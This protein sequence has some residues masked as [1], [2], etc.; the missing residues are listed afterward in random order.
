MPRLVVSI[1]IDQLRTDYLE[2]FMPYYSTQGFKKLLNEGAV[3]DNAVYT[4]QPVDRASAVASI[5][6]GTVPR[7]NGITGTHWLDKSTLFPVDCVDDN[8]CEGLFTKEKASP[9]NLTATTIGD[10]LK[11][12]TDGVALVYSIAKDKEAAILSGGHAADGVFWVDHANK[13]WCSSKFYLKKAPAWMDS[14]NILNVTDPSKG[15]VNPEITKLALHCVSS[16]SMGVDATPDMLNVTYDAK[17]PVGKDKGNLLLQDTYIQLDR[18]IETLISKIETKVGRGNVLFVLTGTGYCND[19]EPD[20]EKFRIQTGTFYINRTANLLNMYLGALYGSDKYVENCYN[21]EIYL[22]TKKIEQKR[23]NMSEILSRSQSFLMQNSGV[24]NALTSRDMLMPNGNSG[25]KLRNWY[26]QN[27]CGDLIVEVTPGWKLLN[28]DTNQQYTSRES[29]VAFPVI[30]YGYG[31]EAKRVIT[32]ITVD[33]I[34]PT[35]ARFIRIRAPN[36]CSA[37]PLY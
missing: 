2:T 1:T 10:E 37:T 32:P 5:F 3:Y 15:S 35:I 4:F 7:Y 12:Q 30:I 14:Y 11:I 22:N 28:E 9:H 24:A 34:A 31:I 36:A 17:P 13:C 6:T 29:I 26:N 8:S 18:E 21:N 23:I 25:S 20:Y 33:C 19:K 16:T 27:R